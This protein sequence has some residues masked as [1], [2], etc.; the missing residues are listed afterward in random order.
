MV[1][2]ANLGDN[3]LYWA[4]R[5]GGTWSTPA[6]TNATAFSLQPVSVAPLAAGGAVLTFLGTD[7]NGY[8]MTFDPTASTPW[9]PPAAL[10]MGGQPLTVA[11]TVATGICGA[12]AIAAVVQPAGVEL[13]TLASGTWSPPA[14]PVSGTAAMSFA[15]VAT[16]P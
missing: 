9:T 5:S 12:D 4:T 2:Y 7:T 3:E 15:T 8:A 6:L 16:S 14:A 11:P 13:V 10:L 1:V